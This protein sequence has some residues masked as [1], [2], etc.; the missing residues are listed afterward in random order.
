MENEPGT[1]RFIWFYFSISVSASTYPRSKRAQTQKH[2][3]IFRNG[4]FGMKGPWLSLPL[5]ARPWLPAGSTPWDMPCTTDSECIGKNRLPH[6]YTRDTSNRS[7]IPTYSCCLFN[8]F[9]DR[10]TKRRHSSALGSFE[11]ETKVHTV[12]CERS[13]VRFLNDSFKTKLKLCEKFDQKFKI[14]GDDQQLLYLHVKWVH[15]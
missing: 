10:T 7:F 12:G 9:R 13:V 5:V 2:G 4:R 1:I 8:R 15:L 11:T 3:G 14:K 6:L